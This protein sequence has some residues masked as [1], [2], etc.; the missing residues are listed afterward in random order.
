MKPFIHTIANALFN[1]F[2]MPKPSGN[3]TTVASTSTSTPNH[4]L[5]TN[6]YRL[7]TLTLTLTLT[8]FSLHA[9]FNNEWIDYSKPY[10]RIKVASEGIFRIN[11]TALDAAGIGNADAAYYQLWLNGNEVPLFTSVATG[12]I[13]GGGYIEFFGQKNNG[14]LDRNLY[15]NPADYIS[16]N[17][18][19]FTDTA[20]Y[21]LTINTIGNNRR[22]Q[23]IANNLSGTLPPPATN[24]W[25]MVRHNYIS[26]VTKRPYINRGTGA[27]FGETV[28]SSS[29]ERG[30]MASSDDIYPPQSGLDISNREASFSNLLP[31]TGGGNGKLRISIAGASA[32]SRNVRVSINTTTLFEKNFSTY[33]ARIDS[34]TTLSPALLQ[35]TATV[36]VRNL[37]T[38]T[39]DRVVAGFTEIEYPRL[40]DGGGANQLRFY[41]PASGNS[42]YLE[43]SNF[44]HNGIAPVLYNLSTGTRMVAELSGTAQVRLLIPSNANRQEFI[45]INSNTAA[46]AVTAL[47]PRNFVNYSQAINQGNYLLISNALLMGGANNGVAQYKAYRSSANGGGYSANIYDIEQLVDQFAY[48]IKMH[49]LSIK[50]FLRFARQ[51][52]AVAPKFCLLIGKGVTYDEFR[53]KE[54]S[55]LASQIQLVPTFGYPASDNLLASDDL[56]AFPVTPIG[57]LSV[58]SSAEV[59]EYLNKVK[60]YEANQ[61]N[62][63][64]LQADK[65][66][67]KNVVHVVGA[68]DAGTESLIRPYM[69]LYARTISDTLFGGSV[70][71]FNKFNTTTASTIENEQLAN[72]FQKG[73]SLMTYFGHSSATALDYNLDDPNQYNNPGKYPIFLLNGCNAGNFFDFEEARLQTKNTISERYVLAP[74]RGAICMIASTHFGIV[75]GLG[76][77]SNGFYRS[78]SSLNYNQP[79]GQNIKDAITYVF[80]TWG[81]N[82]FVG[83]IHAEQQTLHG[84]PA[85]VVNGFAKPD[86][87]IETQNLTINPSFISIL[88]NSFKLKAYYYNIGRAINDSIT[89]EVK[90]QYPVSLINPNVVTEVIF[91]KKVKAPYFLDSL[92]LT[93]PIL[94]DRDK[95]INKIMV[96]LD[97]DNKIAELSEINN[98]I[99]TDVTIFEDELRP[100]YPYNYSIVNTAT[101][102]LIGSAS[103]P[104]SG[105]KTYRMEVDTTALFNSAFKVTRNITTPGNLLEFDP[106]I[107][108]RDSTVYYWRLGLVPASGTVDRWNNA[109]F[110]YLAGPETGFNQSHF[111]QHTKSTTDRIFIDTASRNW[112][113]NKLA[114]QLL[115]SHSVY[116]TPGYVDDN[117]SLSISVNST[118]VSVSACVGHSTIFNVFDGTTFRPLANRNGAFGSGAFCAPGRENNF[119]WDDR[120][121]ANRDSMMRFMDALPNGSYVVVRKILD[122]PHDAE[123]FAQQLK[124]DELINGQGKSLY[125]K[126]KEAG[127]S[128]IDSFNRARIYILIYRKGDAGFVPRIRLSEG[129]N[130]RIQI[131]TTIVTSDTMGMVTSPLFGPAKSWKEVKWRGRSLENVPGD[132]ATLQ[133]IGVSLTGVE[134]PL[135]TLNQNQQDFSISNISATQYPYLRLKM[136]T[137]DSLFGTPYNL[138][139]WRIYYDPVPEGALASNLV[140]QAKDTLQQGEPYDFKIAFKNIS[141]TPFA[142][143]LRLKLEVRDKANNLKIIVLPR[144]KALQS[145]DTTIVSFTLDTKDYSGLNNIYLAV[146]P[147]NAQPEQFFFNNYLYRS[148]YVAED[149]YKPLLDVTFDGVHILNRDI[150]SAKPMIQIKLKDENRFLALNDTAGMVVKLRFPNESNF[151]TYKWGTD[152]LQFIAANASTDNTATINFYPALS[153]DTEGSEYELQVTGKDR[154]GNRAGNL[155]YSVAFQV[156]NKPMIS[157][158][159]NYPNPFSTST[160]FVFTITGVEVP[161]EF[162]I[163]IL[164]I[165]GKIVKEITR[166]ELGALRIGTNVTDYKWDGTDTYGQ[167]LANGVYIYRVISS[168]DGKQMDKFRLNDGFDQKALDVTDQYFNK[169]G[170][171]KLVILR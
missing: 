86:Y 82:D 137:V 52:F 58:I 3:P 143:S 34:I 101:I 111:Y 169:K 37:N 95:G 63:S 103:N 24:V 121:K 10:Y 5:T 45:L 32:R 98:T 73:F 159:L 22:Y 156:F 123:T 129:I 38:D 26:R 125:H 115:V 165:T 167:K 83:R 46:T 163:Q 127:F 19:L 4:R 110:V 164:T 132:R 81:M 89:I 93:L 17:N 15:R 79:V 75:S 150:V 160:A 128:S 170:Y 50:N 97:T 72:L 54:N 124:A 57:R 92:E 109:S 78:V 39:L 31:Y 41:L 153:T 12:T 77:Y 64:I 36:V 158:L 87:S 6:D 48:G 90:R 99:S 44:A 25:A 55:P 145:G 1:G 114:K 76:V 28:Y 138:R 154:N 141:P 171:G 8:F 9:Q 7:A 149:K 118:I 85:M 152:T 53:W 155:E 162:K 107:T 11:K 108:L 102:K 104:F 135:F 151:R 166:Q 168:L 68:N 148:F 43:I 84:D 131:N 100:V 23:T 113:F 120:I 56:N 88:E 51:R 74:N 49:P 91:R 122:E 16:G 105:S 13:P 65:S 157:N 140:L 126:L 30:E 18:S 35:S 69:D 70:T 60:E 61:R 161:Q 106:G 67:M 21:F 66:W 130:D 20:V 136:T 144:K 146:N 117:S 27:N 139:W 59:V 147:D 96:T 112:Q 134:T 14:A 47:S 133:I 80:Q 142:D 71:T 119:E 33:D 94:P 29:Y 40:P 62:P 116:G 2:A 42:N